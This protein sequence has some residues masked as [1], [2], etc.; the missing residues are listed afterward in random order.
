MMNQNAVRGLFLLCLCLSCDRPTVVD[1]P[2]IGASGGSGNNNKPDGSGGKKGGN[3]P[4]DSSGGRSGTGGAIS[5]MGGMGGE[6]GEMGGAGSGG[7]RASIIPSAGCLLAEP[8]PASLEGELG[9]IPVALP[10]HYDGVSPLPL[11]IAFHAFGS[12]MNDLAETRTG[13]SVLAEDYLIARPRHTLQEGNRTWEG[14]Q[15][16]DFDAV[17][18]KLANNLCFDESRVFGVGN[19]GGG[20]FLVNNACHPSAV[21]QLRPSVFRAIALAGAMGS[22]CTP[23]PSVPLLFI[24]SEQDKIAQTVRDDADGHKALER[25]K[26]NLSCEDSSVFVSSTDYDGATYECADFDDCSSQLRFCS[27]DVP[28]DLDL[29]QQAH[30]EEISLFFADYL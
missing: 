17:Y 22:T 15:I 13:R 25:F 10:P 9:P 5:N 18:E 24:H 16:E 6:M 4:N 12:T 30:N 7:E 19:A 23:W 20:R 2:N 28:I 27:H 29:W 26:T 3:Q 1:D 8:E 14:E 21:E 11:I